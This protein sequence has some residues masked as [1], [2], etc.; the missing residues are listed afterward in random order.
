MCKDEREKLPRGKKKKTDLI[1]YWNLKVRVLLLRR[2][3]CFV[4][5]VRGFVDVKKTDSRSFST[6]TFTS[7]GSSIGST[8][9]TNVPRSRIKL[10][11]NKKERE[12]FDNLANLYSIIKATESIEKLFSLNAISTTDYKRECSLLI[13]HFKNAQQFTNLT[14]PDEI[15]KFMNDYN[16]DCKMAFT[17]LVEIGLP[18][19]GGSG[20]LKAVAE[21][22][23]HF[24]TL[25]DSLKLNMVAV[26]QIQPLFGD[27]VDSVNRSLVQ[28]TGQDR[29]KS[30]L[31]Q[32]NSMKANE[33]LD[34]EQI[35]Q[36]SHDLETAYSNFHRN[37]LH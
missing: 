8:N 1:V 5:N 34:S 14:T 13:S 11:N 2:T 20:D 18:H 33:E 36:L 35:R 25:M 7:T 3:N 16:M 10:H 21:T 12:N 22:V 6:S 30:W 19:S 37:L 23:Q 15:R 32:L 28:F 27:L 9:K 4:R 17:R 26:D 29:L 31:S 24:I